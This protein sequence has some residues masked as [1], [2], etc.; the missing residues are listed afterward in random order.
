MWIWRGPFFRRDEELDEEIRAHLAM[1]KRDRMERG[2]AD[3]DA[4]WAARRE[5][6][7]RTL[8]KETTR[9]MWGWRS[10][11]TLWEDVRH[12]LRMMRRTPGFTTVAVLSVALGIGA[13]TAI[14]SLINT[15]VLR[16]LPVK[17][18]A[19]LVEL[20]QKY[21]GEP[22]GNS[23]WTWRSYEHFRDN[24]HIFT[25]LV[26]FSE[27]RFALRS[28]DVAAEMVDGEYVADNF[29]PVLGV[30]PAMGRLIGAEDDGAAVISW[31]YWKSRFNL[32]P[33]ILGK[34]II[35][36]DAPATIIGVA[37]RD[38][39]GMAVWAK[40]D[41]WL[42]IDAASRRRLRFSLIGRLSPGVSLEQARAEMSVL[43]RF[44]IEE[45]A[46]SSK[47]PVV[48]QMKVEVEPGGAGLSRLRDQ[49]AKPLF[50]LMA[51][52]GLL[53]L[54]ACTNVASLL[55]ARGA[56][57]QAE[58]ALR[59][60]LGAGRFRLVRQALTESLLLSAAGS[61]PGIA[62]AYW[63]ADGLVRILASGRMIP[64][65]PRRLDIPV[66]PDW[67]VL[68]FTVVIAL[69]TGVLFGLAP[70]LR[71]WA[72]DPMAALRD[73]GRA[74]DTRFR[75]LFGKSLVVAQVAFSVVLLSAAG[76]FVRHLSD[77]ENVDLGFRRDHLLLVSLDRT[78]GGSKPEQLLLPYQRLLERLAA[79]PGVKSATIIAPVPI[80]GAGASRFATV[81]GHPERPEDRRYLAVSWVAPRSFET[82]GTPLLAG[83]DFTPADEGRPPVA[84]V[85]QAMAR[86]FFGDGNALGKRV[87]FDGE[88]RA[89]EIVGVV[90][91]AR[92]L[93][94][95]ETTP[96]TVYLNAFQDWHA[97]SN[98]VLRTAID[99]AALIPDARRTVG[100]VLKTAAA[101][102]FRTMAEEVDASIVPERLVAALSGLFGVLGS[103][104]AAV[105]VYGL[106]AYTVARRVNEI[107]IRM[108]L[109]A[110]RRDVMR[111]VTGDALAM[112]CAGLTVGVPLA[113][114]G[115]RMA[116]SLMAGL[117]VESAAPVWFGGLAMVVVGLV[118]A[119]VPARRAARVDPMVALRH[120]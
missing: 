24:N 66:Y 99:P 75:S 31:R 39:S 85:N 25:G 45:R 44:T 81:E 21:P 92:Y 38:F 109:G 26:S 18:P 71:A 17:N 50:V 54:I 63:G 40:P 106:L 16:L 57:R 37:A 67:H 60:S 28:Q 86:Y 12:G 64:G 100:A 8:V 76:L 120:E 43:Y 68:L 56:A 5:F 101:P 7:N 65:L 41:V 90:G 3:G 48:R 55:L 19:E 35:V 9:Q 95:V 10:L 112:V 22:H 13:N 114:W 49:F 23:F 59:V 107:G 96:R 2:E 29:F 61:L 72:S 116:G 36:N 102:R 1:A 89:Y 87:T 79:I 15:L 20:L 88:E 11:E 51:V 115:R 108:A 82:L 32:D 70:A 84:I 6:G 73:G 91:D 119:S 113:F 58:M 104:L 53:L 77:L 80:S 105:G 97:P 47:D 27:S 74:S 78:S 34:Q 52:V 14:F 4:E 98:F 103:V 111:M 33:G 42:P 110:D 117:P 83:R 93:E 94:I 30:R 46:G 62:L 118:A 69:F